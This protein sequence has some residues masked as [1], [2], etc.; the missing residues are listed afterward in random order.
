MDSHGNSP[1]VSGPLSGMFS[2]SALKA[3]SAEEAQDIADRAATS[4][5][6]V[7]ETSTAAATATVEAASADADLGS[8]GLPAQHG[9]AE[10]VPPEAA[11]QEDTGPA[12]VQEPVGPQTRRSSPTRASTPGA[13]PRAARGGKAAGTSP[14][15]TQA[16]L[17]EVQVELALLIAGHTTEIEQLQTMMGAHQATVVGASSDMDDMLSLIHI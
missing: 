7:A 3:I 1:T 6:N 9:S 14:P 8:Q 11:A 12:G 10:R 5:A 15:V 13:V 2:A 4:E 16:D 17:R